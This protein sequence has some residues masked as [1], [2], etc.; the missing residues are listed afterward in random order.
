MWMDNRLTTACR[1]G[2]VLIYDE[3]TRSRPEANNVLLSVLSEGLLNLPKLGCN[4][5]GYVDV[6][7]QFRAIFTS[8]PQEY[9]GVHK[10]QDALLDRLITIHMDHYDRRTEAA[11]TAASG[12]VCAETA[13]R[14]VDLVRCIRQRDPSGQ[15]PSIRAAIMLA[16]VLAFRELTCDPQQSAGRPR[17]PRRAARGR[18]VRQGEGAHAL[19]RAVAG[20]AGDDLGRA[21]GK[22]LCEPPE[23]SFSTR[24]EEVLA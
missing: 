5:D 11:I 3:F 23:V 10:S 7:P 8:N 2:H 6:H 12:G 21:A 19:L 1:H 20:D 18:I 15:H 22:A 4:G 9:A 24:A 16:R 17:L 13:E 14:I